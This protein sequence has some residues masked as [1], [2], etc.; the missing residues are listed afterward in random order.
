[1]EHY[2]GKA[3]LLKDECIDKIIENTQYKGVL[4]S[5][6]LKPLKKSPSLP[7]FYLLVII[8]NIII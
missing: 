3:Q 4:S 7:Y 5:T 6:R 1:M 2:Q 8:I